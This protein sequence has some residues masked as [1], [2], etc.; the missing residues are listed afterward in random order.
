[1]VAVLDMEEVAV[2]L[3]EVVA[4]EV[5]DEVADDDTALQLLQQ[6]PN[7]RLPRAQARVQSFPRRVRSLY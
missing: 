1:M 3:N 5:S 2:L 4:D 6:S 7:G